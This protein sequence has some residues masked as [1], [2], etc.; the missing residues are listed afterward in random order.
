M[1][2]I[3]KNIKMKKSLSFIFGTLSIVGMYAENTFR[4][5]FVW[6]MTEDLSKHYLRL[7][8]D[9]MSG[10]PSPNLERMAQEGIVFDNAF[11]NAPVSS[12]ARSTLI[13]SCYGTRLGVS[14]HRRSRSVILPESVRMFPTYLRR[15]GY[16]T[17]NAA[18][19]DY[20]CETDPEA[21]DII[22]GK[23]GDWRKR[24]DKSQPFFHVRTNTVTHE[25]HLHFSM[26]DIHKKK[27]ETD[28]VSVS[29]HPMHPDTPISRY[30]M[31]LSMTVSWNQTGNSAD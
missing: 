5:N 6:Y 9:D 11:S 1:N 22:N 16:H 17:S 14:L 26:A 15:T 31:R 18:K 8:N 19:T 2:T 4:P 23:L 20:N 21:W 10:A 29:I 13:T 7:Y 24:G 30:P 28:P 25:G 12:A 27:T 3:K